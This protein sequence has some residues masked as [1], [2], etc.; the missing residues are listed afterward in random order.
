MTVRLAVRD[1]EV[2]LAVTIEDR[3]PRV[4]QCTCHGRTSD[5]AS[6]GDAIARRLF[7][8]AVVR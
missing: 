4:C 8:Q 5:D 1:G 7:A 6:L 2:E 3:K